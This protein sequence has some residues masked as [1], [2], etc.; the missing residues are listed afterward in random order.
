MKIKGFV[1]AAGI[2]MT[3]FLFTTPGA[4]AQAPSLAAND[5]YALTVETDNGKETFTVIR[6]G[7][8]EEQFY[9][10][11][12][13][14]VIATEENG[15]EVTPVF[16]LLSYQTKT[17]DKKLVQ[18]GIL[19]LSMVTGVPQETVEKI[20]TKLGE[21][22]TL[23]EGKEIKLSPMPIKSSEVTLY[24]L[25]GNML[26]QAPPKGGIAPIFGTQHMPFM[27]KLKELGTDVVE[28]LC[29]KN[30]GLPVLITY[31]FQAMTPKA[32]FEVT[33]NWD[34]CFKHFSTNTTVGLEI[35]QGG[36]SGNL[37][38]D[39]AKIR[40]DFV[41]NG[42]IKIN[43]LSGEAAT[44]EQLD[45]IMNPVLNMITK[46]LFEQ[47]H[48]PETISPATTKEL[49]EQDKNV[50]KDV[51]KGAKDLYATAYGLRTADLKVGF[52]LK[53]SETVKKG[54]F[55]FKFD[56]QAIV[57]RTTC[58]GGLLGIGKFSEKI[59]KKCITTMPVGQWE[60]AYYVL[61]SVGN[62]SSLGLNTLSISVTPQEKKADGTWVQL[63]TQKIETAYFNKLKTAIWTDK[64]DK[65]VTSFVY[66]LK[67]LYATNGFKH[68]NYRFEVVTT[69]EPKGSKSLS[70]TS[71]APLF[72]GELPITSPTDLVDIV[73]IDGS[74]LT[75]G[76]EEGQVKQVV[77][78]LKAGKNTW[79]V[80]MDADNNLLAFMVPV[81]E[82]EIKFTSFNF[83][84]TKGKLG[85]WK[86]CN[87]NLRDLEP[88]LYIMLYDGD[89]EAKP[90]REKLPA[91]AILPLD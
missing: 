65:K 4:F 21:K 31:T 13:K 8:I 6:D 36:L 63:K 66:P 23:A 89:W 14:P 41:S 49:K 24:D 53:D 43:S 18:G 27:L 77:G 73:T 72:D 83:I 39:F 2:F 90:D 29:T 80:K 26:D 55:T 5:Q 44:A 75:Y 35:A 34:A 82:K 62:P 67:A 58:F 12:I 16:Q 33:V 68:E 56:R 74:C 57:E 52:A 30:G 7:R 1:M 61:P 85:Q 15:G 38:L 11:P 60:S 42:L 50:L 70:V 64:D 86:D 22:I 81:N 87:A 48:A 37:G 71:Y 10:V 54:S 59:Q 79:T 40:E 32:G 78:Q 28:A 3:S 9:Y 46:E 51:V 17:T 69:L 19:Q 25:G 20:K 84:Q 91:D 88:S 76:T 45:E 47:I